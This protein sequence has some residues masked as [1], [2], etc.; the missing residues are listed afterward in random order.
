MFRCKQ[1]AGEKFLFYW[2]DGIFVIG[3]EAVS[4]VQDILA[5]ENRDFKVKDIY[6]IE[7]DAKQKIIM[8]YDTKRHWDDRFK[9]KTDFKPRPFQLPKH[10][11][12]K[13]REN[14]K[15]R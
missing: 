10:T 12:A 8:V 14:E 1:S 3:K 4:N 15:Q 5:E 9:I 11:K 7:F 2:I 13:I 6:R